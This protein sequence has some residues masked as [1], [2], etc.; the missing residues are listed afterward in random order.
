MENKTKTAKIC[1]KMQEQVKIF[2]YNFKMVEE[3]LN[4]KQSSTREKVPL[5]MWRI[6]FDT[7][8]EQ[9]SFQL[10]FICHIKM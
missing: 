4:L 8:Q 2:H 3:N 9:L 10:R 1:L 5:H 6:S 7:S